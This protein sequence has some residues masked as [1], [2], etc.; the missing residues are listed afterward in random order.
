M[1]VLQADAS[2][3]RRAE[4]RKSVC[5]MSLAFA[6]VLG[7]VAAH[8]GRKLSFYSVFLQAYEQAAC[9]VALRV[10]LF[11]C[12][13]PQKCQNA[14]GLSTFSS[15][16]QLERRLCATFAPSDNYLEKRVFSTGKTSF[17]VGI[18]R[19]WLA[20][21]FVAARC[22]GVACPCGDANPHR[23]LAFLLVALLLLCCWWRLRVA[24]GGSLRANDGYWP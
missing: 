10:A 14:V 9:E 20:R 13:E 2:G 18:L 8:E 15:V 6:A 23:V 21:L 11:C 7:V 3:A 12:F 1:V 22:C 16:M 17:P 24:G 19:T 5:C 4:C